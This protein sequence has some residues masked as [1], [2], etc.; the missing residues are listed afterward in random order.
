[1]SKTNFGA[2]PC[3]LVGTNPLNADSGYSMSCG[4]FSTMR[5]RERK[6]GGAGSTTIFHLYVK[7]PTYFEAYPCWLMIPI[8][9][10]PNW[11]QVC[12]VSSC[13]GS[14]VQR[15]EGGGSPTNNILSLDMP[16]FQLILGLAHID[17]WHQ[18]TEC[19]SLSLST[20]QWSLRNNMERLSNQYYSINMSRFQLILGFIHVD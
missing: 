2:Y 17:K 5:W 6:R 20:P 11:A 18:S 14:L 8:Y 16:R 12:T 13:L 19:H 10:M 4:I 15:G 9:C 1:M 3:S 7:I